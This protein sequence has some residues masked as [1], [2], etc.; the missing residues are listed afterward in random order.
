[1]HESECKFA[2]MLG[3]WVKRGAQA[4]AA[5]AGECGMMVCEYRRS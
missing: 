4:A 2:E 3:F 1:V 5:A